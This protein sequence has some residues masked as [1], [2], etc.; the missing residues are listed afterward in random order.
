MFQQIEADAT[1]LY[2]LL[3]PLIQEE[4]FCGERATFSGTLFKKIVTS[5]VDLSSLP[6]GSHKRE[7]V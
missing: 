6:F 2:Q 4:A 5:I 7:R 1:G 3:H